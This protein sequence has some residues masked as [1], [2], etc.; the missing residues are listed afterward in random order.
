MVFP[1]R[2]LI[3]LPLTVFV[4]GCHTD[5]D[6]DDVMSDPSFS[7][8][9]TVTNLTAGQPL[10]PAAVVIHNTSWKAFALGEPASVAL[11]TLA[12][13]GDNSDFVAAADSDSNVLTAV[14]GQGP[15]TPG[16]TAQVTATIQAQSTAGLFLT[17]ASM[18]VNTNDA[19]AALNGVSLE[20]IAVGQSQ[21]YLTISYDTGTEANSETADT[22]PGP[23][24]SG[25][26]EGFNA[27]RDDLRNAVYVHAGV[28]T[29]DDGLATSTLD[30]AQRWDNPIARVHIER[31]R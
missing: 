22:V 14:S 5:S 6:S 3:L 9:I 28:V 8:Q 20:D 27:T 29:R 31:L 19:L 2:I 30:N 13:A 7:Y 21:T 18:P 16:A 23:A 15:I 12:E 25:L 26:A 24:A 4:A 11:E 10:S 1:K 17:W